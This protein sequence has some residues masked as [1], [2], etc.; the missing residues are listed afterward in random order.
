MFAHRDGEVQTNIPLA[1]IQ[2][3]RQ[4]VNSPEDL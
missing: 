4:A 2:T 3:K 1:V